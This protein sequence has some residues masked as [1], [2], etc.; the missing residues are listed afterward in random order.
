MIHISCFLAPNIM[1]IFAGDL[2][3]LRLRSLVL[4]ALADPFA[5]LLRVYASSQ[6]KIKLTMEAI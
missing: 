1:R 6:G 3:F 2:I 4:R 5:V